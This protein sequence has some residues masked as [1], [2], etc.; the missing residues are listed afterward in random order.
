MSACHTTASST[1]KYEQ[2]S[3]EAPKDGSKK[4]R[5]TI[6][7][8][9]GLIDLDDPGVAGKLAE[10]LAGKVGEQ[11]VLFAQRMQ[12]G[13]L[14]ASVAI[15]LDVMGEFMEAEVTEVA[16][17]KGKHDAHRAAYRHGHEDATVAL[18]GRRVPVRRPRVRSVEAGEVHLESY[19]AFASADLLTAHTVAAMMAGLSTRRYEGTLEPVGTEVAEASSSTS[20]SSVSRRFVAATA[21]RLAEFRARPLDDARWLVIFVDGFDFAGHTMVGALG[22]TADGTKVPLG[23]VEGSTENAA[24]VR[25]LISGLRDRGVDASD[26]ILFVLDGAKALTRAVKDVFGDKALIQRCRLHKER[27]VAD[28]LPEAERLWVLRKMR[29]AWK[30]PDA[31][32]AERSLRDL[33]GQI[34][35]INPDAAGSMREGLAEMFTV[36]RL[37][38][39]GT[40]LA[41]VMSTNPVESMIEIVRNHA[42]N[43]KHWQRGDMRLRWAAAGMLEAAKQFRRVKGYSQLPQLASAIKNAT[44]KSDDS[45]VPVTPAA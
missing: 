6:L 23:V 14:A 7:P 35:Q 19:E 8:G 17:P 21:E 24:V 32:Q 3:N 29:Q 9:I 11:L 15:G 16:G 10:R 27:N 36:T 44:S 25:G 30:N 18:G 22:V 39:R 34:E 31:N 40:M 33:A 28:H 5:L 45:T 37:G 12:E 38:V 20:K 4:Q 42:R 1:K 43:V 41:T 26:G 2:T 13:L